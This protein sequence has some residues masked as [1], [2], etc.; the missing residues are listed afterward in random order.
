MRRLYCPRLGNYPLAPFLFPN[1]GNTGTTNALF[2][3][4]A[5]TYLQEPVVLVVD[6][7]AKADMVCI[8]HPYWGVRDDASYINDVVQ[9]AQRHGKRILVYA[10]GDRADA[11][12]IPNARVLRTSQYRYQWREN[13]IMMP[14]YAEDLGEA[15]AHRKGDAPVIG[16]CGWAD[17]ASLQNRIGTSAQVLL[18]EIAAL[19]RPERGAEK[20][21]VWV[22]KKVLP[23]FEKSANVR[24]A[25]IRRGSF[26][27]HRATISVDPETARREYVANMRDCDLA[28]CVRGDGNYSVRFYEA[29]GMGRVPLFIDTACVL[30]LEKTIRYDDLLVRVP[31]QDIDHAPDRIATWWRELTD[32]RFAAMQKSAREAFAKYLRID[33]FFA[34]LFTEVL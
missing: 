27:G 21:G 23:V 13:D 26:S 12:D 20:K 28:L 9:T 22:R 24:T 29:L 25:F 4:K 33:R 6:D 5:F 3:P 14:A 34:H 10:Y 15:P 19:S 16:F 17:Y 11:I 1:F 8:P 18:T 30:P 31:W 2:T 7:P 32:E